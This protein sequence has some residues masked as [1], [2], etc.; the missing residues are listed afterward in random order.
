VTG[1][2]R[3]GQEVTQDTSTKTWWY[4]HGL[5]PN[6]TAIYIW[7]GERLV[8][9]VNSDSDAEEIVKAHNQRVL[10]SP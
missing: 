3:A 8:A 9:V 10:S 5:G 6:D 2:G 4:Q 7:E 1:E